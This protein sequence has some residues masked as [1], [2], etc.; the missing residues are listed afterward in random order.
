MSVLQIYR[1]LPGSG[2]TARALA[3]MA[4][5]TRGSIARVNRDDL[6]VDVFHTG[7]EPDSTEFE[8]GL[9]ALQHQMIHL[10]LR[11]EVN[12]IC[13]DT[14]LHDEHVLA[15]V[16]IAKIAGAG[17]TVVDDFTTVPLARCIQQ[18]ATRAPRY[19]VGP[20][21]ITDM[22]HNHLAAHYPAPLPR[23]PGA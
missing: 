14:N 11:R 20:D 16:G 21:V 19:Q 10:L 9:T 12:V 1:G 22:F 2:K 23:P 18:D 3:L 4:T 13:D 5:W 7:Y 17:W 15:L 6:R 8:D